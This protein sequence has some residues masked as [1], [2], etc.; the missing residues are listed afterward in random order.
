MD[1]FLKTEPG[2]GTRPARKPPGEGTGLG[3]SLSREIIEK[4]NGGTLRFESEEG[5]YSE[6]IITLPR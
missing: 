1:R 6:F 5:Q 2:R 3:L 4:G